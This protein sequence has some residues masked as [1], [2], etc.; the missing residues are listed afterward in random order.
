M[1]VAIFEGGIVA[2]SA[3][4]EFGQPWV[5]PDGC[6]A[7]VWQDGMQIGQ[8][9]PIPPDLHGLEGGLTGLDQEA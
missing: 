6:S 8:P 7:T 5:L 2:N 4:W 3:V 9:W 1:T